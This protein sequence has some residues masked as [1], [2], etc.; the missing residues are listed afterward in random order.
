MTVFLAL[1]ALPW[2]CARS[3]VIPSGDAVF[4]R[5]QERLRTT[6]RLVDAEKPREEERTLFLQAEGFY[7][8][9]FE[10]P[11]R[12]VAGYMAEGAAAVTDLPGLQSLA[13]SLD[14]ADLRFE[15]SSGACQ[16]WETLLARYPSTS[17]RPLTLYRLG[18]AYRTTSLEGLPRKSGDEAF[19]ELARE[20]PASPLASL[21][22][23]AREVPWKSKPKATAWSLLPGA[24]QIY[25]GR[26]GSGIL[27]LGV[28]LTS[29]ALVVLP[30]YLAYER[31]QDLNWGRDWPLLAG[32]MVG[33]IALSLDYTSAYQDAVR[34][35][36]R[37]NEASE[38][39]FRKTHPEAP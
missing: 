1:G 24:G 33:A 13:S 36:V 27:G 15:A 26:V 7:E 35:V 21:G 18:W 5:A 29:A 31:R 20:Y 10:Y 17:L 28:G 2:A 25:E 38:D 23:E 32:G 3:V 9:R 16:L 6:A 30:S 19:D 4:A 22:G 37:F 12:S 8:Y 34:G 39:E 11:P 14:L